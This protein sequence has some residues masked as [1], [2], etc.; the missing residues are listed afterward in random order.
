MSRRHVVQPP[1]DL[2]GIE[3]AAREAVVDEAAMW[4]A[5]RM[6][7]NYEITA[8]RPTTIIG[9]DGNVGPAV[10]IT[11]TTIPHKVPGVVTVPQI[12][13]TP[14]RVADI[15]GAAATNAEAIQAL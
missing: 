5:A 1:P 13:Y 14:D 9:P 7:D 4:Q 12:D 15:V 8:Q 10:T 2:V 11:F 6:A 3:P